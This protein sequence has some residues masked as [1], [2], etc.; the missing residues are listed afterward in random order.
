MKAFISLALAAVAS[1]NYTS[2]DADFLAYL[3]RFGK[4][5]GTVEEYL[6]RMELFLK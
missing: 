1:A 4:S 2:Q 3:A 6:F 5:Y